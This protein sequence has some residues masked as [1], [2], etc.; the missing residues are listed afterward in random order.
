MEQRYRERLGRYTTAMRNEQPDRVPIRPF[1]AEFT[2]VVAGYTCQELA[3]D[4][5][6]AFAAVRRCASDFEW[7]AVVPNMLATWTGMTQAMGLRYYMTPGI[8]LPANVGHQYREPPEEEAWM[9][10]DEYDALIED[11]T[12]FLYNVWFPRVAEP[13]SG[14]GGPVTFEHN[15][16]LIKGPMAMM[17]FFQAWGA[18]ERRLRDECGMPAAIAGMLRA[19]LD[20]IADKL[21][22]YLGLLDDLRERPRKVLAACEALMPFLTHFAL[23][24]A[25]PH[26]NVPIGFWMHRG[27][28]PFIN[29]DHFNH[30][31]W[32]TLK[33]IIQELWAH[34]HQ[35][36]FYAE[37]NWDR[38][39]DAFAELPERSIVYHVDQGDLATV[40][41]VLGGRFCLSGGIS[42]Y[43]LAFRSPDEVRRECKR[44]IELVGRDGGYIMDASAIVQREATVENIRA[45]TEATL[46]YGV[47]STGHVGPPA[48]REAPRTSSDAAVPGSFVPASRCHRPPGVCVPWS[49]KKR[50]LPEIQGDELLCE[51]VWQSLDTLA[52][53][54]IWW[55]VMA[56]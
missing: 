28:V 8:D 35:T 15:L 14:L 23:A 19:P 52:A 37:G 49:E 45:M 20:F 32:P 5:E 25:D 24:T 40:H 21:R 30:I 51:R 38:H 33:P 1:V 48:V 42:N 53:M 6:N 39:L 50:S 55:I 12:G 27:C 44:V 9:R 10:P 43:L 31:F 54:Y 7:D 29:Y 11:P 18:Q 2:G 17:Q 22:G 56:F 13:L 41:R 16:A 26:K 4:Y 3:H 46:E 34:G 36:L 47:Y